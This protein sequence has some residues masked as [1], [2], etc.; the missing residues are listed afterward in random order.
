MENV[1]RKLCSLHANILT[2]DKIKK[3]DAAWEIDGLNEVIKNLRRNRAPGPDKVAAELIKWLNNDNRTKVLVHYN[4]IL[5]NGDVFVHW[6][7][8]T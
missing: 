4:D 8:Q 5:M 3:K 1:R 6:T 2:K 7:M